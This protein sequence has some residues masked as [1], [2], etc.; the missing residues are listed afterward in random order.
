MAGYELKMT[1][2]QM[3]SNTKYRNINGE[4]DHDSAN[5]THHTLINAQIF[6]KVLLYTTLGIF[7]STNNCFGQ[8]NETIRTGR[9]GQAIGAYAVGKN[10]FQTQTGVDFGGSNATRL[11]S[12]TVAP[13]TVLRF[14]ITKT[15]EINSGWEYRTDKYKTDTSSYVQSGLSG[16]NLGMRFNILP[17]IK[18][19]PS[20]GF[21]FSLKM[22]ILSKD[23]N[24]KFVAP[25]FLLIAT[26]NFSDRWSLTANAGA[27]YNGNDAEP[28]GIY[29][30]NLSYALSSKFGTFI[31]NYGHYYKSHL[32]NRWDAGIAYLA[33]N[34]LQLDIYGGAGYNYGKMDYFV[35]IGVS[36]RALTVRNKSVN[37]Q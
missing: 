26:E 23:Y 16:A 7:I 5:P 35:S 10:V 1:Q 37:N 31:E 9:P 20:L 19:H 8:F 2:P 21:Q 33:N 4:L 6:C 13:N 27:S 14:G 30:L 34:N 29:V 18:Q 28:T 24:P 22:P 32:E 12:N 25:R 3:K 17:A 36:Y 11:K 15:A